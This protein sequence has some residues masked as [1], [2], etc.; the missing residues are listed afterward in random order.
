MTNNQEGDTSEKVS[1]LLPS[2]KNT[3]KLLKGGGGRYFQHLRAGLNKKVLTPTTL[4]KE[5][6]ETF[7]S[8]QGGYQKKHFSLR[9]P[10]RKG[11]G[12]ACK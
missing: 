12:E 10:P 11:K 3:Q 6:K 4:E 5:K 8:K 2:P 1:F 7:N 9:G